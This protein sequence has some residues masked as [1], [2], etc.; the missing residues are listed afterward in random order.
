MG[1]DASASVPKNWIFG[2]LRHRFSRTWAIPS[3]KASLFTTLLRTRRRERQ[4]VSILQ[5]APERR[6]Q[7]FRRRAHQRGMAERK[8]MIDREH[9]LPITKQAEILKVSRGSAYYLP[10]PVPSA[11]LSIM[12]R[13][14]RLQPEYPFAGSRMLR[15]LP[16][17]RAR[18]ARPSR[19]PNLSPRLNRC[20]PALSPA[21]SES[22]NAA[23]TSYSML[24]RP[25]IPD[26]VTVPRRCPSVSPLKQLWVAR[27]IFGPKLSH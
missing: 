8:A 14:D 1:L 16:K 11:D 4:P 13:L 12:Q 25:C 2:Q 26:T 20:R 9:N 21:S 22:P 7:F 19:Q 27:Y 15:G 6:D 18:P 3:A 10:R 5:G 17:R 24:L 23:L